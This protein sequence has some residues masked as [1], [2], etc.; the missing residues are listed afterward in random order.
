MFYL[1]DLKLGAR[2]PNLPDEF[3]NGVDQILNEY[4]LQ[5]FETYCAHPEKLSVNFENDFYFILPLCSFC[6]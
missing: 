6:M 2:H 1:I 3:K 4:L 5:C